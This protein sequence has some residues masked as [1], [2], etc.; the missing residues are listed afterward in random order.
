MIKKEYFKTRSEMIDFLQNCE[1][2]VIEHKNMTIIPFM[3]DMFRVTYDDESKEE[4]E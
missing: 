2:K 1:H 4:N 3:P